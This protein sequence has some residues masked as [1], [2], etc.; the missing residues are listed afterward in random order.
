MQ[1]VDVDPHSPGG[2]SAKGTDA[3]RPGNPSPL[4][5]SNLPNEV[6]S[7]V[8]EKL[9]DEKAVLYNCLFVAKR[10]YEV[11]VRHLW[12]NL[13]F[14]L[15]ARG[16]LRMLNRLT[17]STSSP[18]EDVNPHFS[19]V[20]HLEIYID[21]CG[22]RVNSADRCAEIKETIMRYIEIL[23]NCPSVRFLRLSL[24]PF[25]QANANDVQWEELERNNS[26][27]DELVCTAASREYSEIFLDI[28]KPKYFFEEGY[29]TILQN[30][31]EMLGPQVTSLRFCE[32]ATPI[33]QWFGPLRQ[34]RRLDAEILG[35]PTEDELSKFWDAISVIPLEE[36][37]LSGV[38]LPRNRQFK[39]WISLRTIRLNQ[40]S[41]VQYATST[42]LQSFPNLRS[43]AFHNPNNL[44]SK[45]TPCP[46]TKVICTKLRTISFTR[47]SPQENIISLIARYC[48]LLQACMPPNNTSDGDI[49][50][51]IDSCP[52]LNT[53]LI[54][55]C[56]KLTST[57]IGHMGR[58]HH[59]RSVLF[60]IEHV[61]FFTQECIYALAKNC[62]D[63][64]SRSCRVDTGKGED[65]RLQRN[66]VIEKLPGNVAYRKWLLSFME[67]E[68]SFT[69]GGSLQRIILDIDGI[70]KETGVYSSTT[71]V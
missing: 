24:H 67:K 11:A 66:M 52:G 3:D 41:D 59:L 62:P 40:F 6:L 7:N 26:L 64:H 2:R 70:R 37:N 34:L 33:W 28:A 47:C 30:Y 54:D 25:T 8:L 65:E 57:A 10:W 38:S 12:Y 35:S 16:Q 61:V 71:H 36:L 19:L 44:P 45:D 48:P 56:P 63:L 60:N 68:H 53:L 15:I 23:R 43:V 9:Q 5:I 32:G 39:N 51:L 29:S 69:P 14:S 49:I 58:A 21:L 1:V 55:S 27:I 17:P 46:I 18:L 13:R 20:R 42:I 31:V 4:A 22:E 50:T